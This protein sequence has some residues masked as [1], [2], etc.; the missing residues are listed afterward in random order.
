MCFVPTHLVFEA[1]AL[2]PLL[3]RHLYE[4]IVL[5]H[6]PFLQRSGSV[7]HSSMS[8]PST[9]TPLSMHSCLYSSEPEIGHG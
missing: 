9:C 6:W 5:T 2:K 7:L 3:Q 4:P 8:E 1:S